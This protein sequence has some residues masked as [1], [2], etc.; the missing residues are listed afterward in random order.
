MGWET[1]PLLSDIMGAIVEYSFRIASVAIALALGWIAGKV[2]GFFIN[3][4]VGKMGLETA[5]RKT[6]VGR[7]ILRTGY[8][9]GSFFAAVG[10][11]AIYL[12]TILSALKLLAIPIL[13]DSAQALIEY[14]PNLFGGG[15]ILVTGF[16]F[17]D[18]IGETIEKGSSSTLQSS[19]LSVIVRVVLY[20]IVITVALAQMRIDVTILYI[21]AQAFAWSLAIAIGIALGWNLKDRI[22]ALLD[23]MA[24][25]KE[26]D[27]NE[28][29]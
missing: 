7:A 9:A 8:T 28:K 10:R 18:W 17:T 4:M 12:F 22:G 24:S 20:F 13:T 26:K 25:S 2:A 6:S 1:I 11:G 23:K 19:I 15:L 21:F 5:F 14:L 16:I 27:K 29:Q 3:S